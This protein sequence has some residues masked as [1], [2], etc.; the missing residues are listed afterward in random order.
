MAL[1]IIALTAKEILAYGLAAGAA[2]GGVGYLFKSSGEAAD[3]AGNG[4]LKLAVAA[5][6]AVW[7][8]KQVK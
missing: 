8:Y 1:P 7:V 4:A 3:N 6:V 5:V 2:T